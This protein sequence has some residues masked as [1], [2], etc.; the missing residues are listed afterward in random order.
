M[1]VMK[2]CL[3]PVECQKKIVSSEL[4]HLLENGGSSLVFPIGLK[5]SMANKVGL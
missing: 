5:E 1:L 3:H 4:I 2:H